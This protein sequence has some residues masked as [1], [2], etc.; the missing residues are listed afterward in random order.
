MKNKN[1]SHKR[2]PKNRET[3]MKKDEEN[4]ENEEENKEK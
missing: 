1:V 2:T 3:I 4:K